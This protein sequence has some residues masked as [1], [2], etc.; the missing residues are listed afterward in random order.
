MTRATYLK[1]IGLMLVLTV[2]QSVIMLIPDWNGLQG[3]AEA[4]EIDLLF[5]VMIVLSSFVFSIVIVML[6]YCI[7]KYR[8]KPGD[9]SDGK[10]IHGN[11]RLEIAWTL[12][13][14]V[15][16]LF[17]AAYSWVILDDIEAEASDQMPVNVTAQQFKWTFEYP[18]TG[19]VTD[20]FH[21]PS[22]TQLELHLTSLEVLHSFWVPEWRIKRDLVPIAEGNPSDVD[23]VVRVTPD[24]EGEYTLMCTEYCGWGHATMRAPVVV[25]SQEEF[26]AWMADQEAAQAGTG[27]EAAADE[28]AAA[29][30]EGASD[31]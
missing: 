27:T 23:N 25:E 1:L 13:P 4:D 2:V 8:A 5:D 12:I 17:A 30:D 15:I 16:V 9:E 31:K 26:D 18:D 28:E 3:S 7:Y 20:E 21:V 10:P 22:G 24:V 29:E 14:T 11:T 19:V 6:G